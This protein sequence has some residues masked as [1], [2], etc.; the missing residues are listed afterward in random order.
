MI[1]HIKINVVIYYDNNIIIR[2]SSKVKIYFQ[3]ASVIV[4]KMFKN[5]ILF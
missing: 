1:T 2:K 3:K 4:T 5:Q